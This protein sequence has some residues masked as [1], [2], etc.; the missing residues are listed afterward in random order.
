M[1]G[2]GASPA[3]SNGWWGQGRTQH[4]TG[5]ALTLLTAQEWL[6]SSSGLPPTGASVISCVSSFV[7][8]ASDRQ[9]GHSTGGSQDLGAGQQQVQGQGG[10]PSIILAR[11]NCS[12]VQSSGPC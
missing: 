5:A 1:L 8:L 11:G 3:H 10:G 9:V 2:E 12:R 4:G 6:Q 7:G